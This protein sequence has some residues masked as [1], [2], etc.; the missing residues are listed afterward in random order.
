MERGFLRIVVIPT[1]LA[2]IVGAGV[3]LIYTSRPHT[4][5]VDIYYPEATPPSAIAIPSV[6]DV[7]AYPDPYDPDV[8]R[9][10]GQGQGHED[11]VPEPDNMAQ[12]HSPWG[13]GLP[14]DSDGKVPEYNRPL[15][16]S[17]AGRATYRS[18]MG[19]VQWHIAY[20]PVIY[21]FGP[22]D[23]HKIKMH[24]RAHA[25]GFRHWEGS[26]STNPAY[27]PGIRLCYC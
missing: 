8:M 11:V 2:I 14:H 24:E 4:G 20:D 6:P 18:F 22:T 3:Y 5:S 10:E 7:L 25:R 17:V 15:P 21:D 1:L 23:I 16:G 12:I 26:P 27:Y 9:L 19:R 13:K